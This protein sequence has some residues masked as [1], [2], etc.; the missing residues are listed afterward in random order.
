LERRP[1]AWPFIGNPGRSQEL[2]ILNWGKNFKEGNYLAH[3][4]WEDQALLK[5]GIL[6]MNDIGLIRTWK[7][8]ELR[9][10]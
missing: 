6:D 9:F 10:D 1:K 8:R 4:S 5:L 3:S 2:G 7:E